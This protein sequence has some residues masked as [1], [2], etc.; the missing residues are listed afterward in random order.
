MALLCLFKSFKHSESLHKNIAQ[1][2][3]KI[4][5][6]NAVTLE[7]CSYMIAYLLATYELQIT[8][9]DNIQLVSNESRFRVSRRISGSCWC[10]DGQWPNIRP[11]KQHF[12]VF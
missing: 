2:V 6:L 9:K 10:V 1:F 7:W 12:F 4:V 11:I 8:K 3:Q 5:R